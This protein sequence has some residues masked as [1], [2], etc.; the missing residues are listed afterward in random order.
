MT[1]IDQF[2]QWLTNCP[3]NSWYSRSHVYTNS[4]NNATQTN[5]LATLQQNK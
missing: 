5:T 3:Y 4:T 1:V 2:M